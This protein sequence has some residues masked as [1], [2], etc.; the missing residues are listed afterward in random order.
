MAA[1]AILALSVRHSRAWAGCAVSSR[2]HLQTLLVIKPVGAFT[3]HHKSLTPQHEVQPQIAIALV[4]RSQFFHAFDGGGIVLR[5]E[6]VLLHRPCQA[7]D[8]AR[9]PVAQADLA[10]KQ[11]QRFALGHRC[12]QF[13]ASSSFI[14]DMSGI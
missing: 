12:H 7:G 1:S 9:P 2:S 3:V 4:L 10:L 8:P 5:Y 13:S 6:P 11:S 14:D